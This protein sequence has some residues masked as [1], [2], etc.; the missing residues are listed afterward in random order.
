MVVIVCYAE[1]SVWKSWCECS[2]SGSDSWSLILNEW[3]RIMSSHAVPVVINHVVLCLANGF[4][5]WRFM[6]C[7][8][9]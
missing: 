3:L 5:L 7:Q 6:L 8:C 9:L 1:P 4:E 2:A